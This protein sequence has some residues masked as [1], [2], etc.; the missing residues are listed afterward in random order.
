MASLDDD[1][2]IVVVLHYWA[3]LTLEGVADRVGWPIGTVKSRSHRALTTMRGR[4]DVQRSR[5]TVDDRRRRHPPARRSWQRPAAGGAHGPARLPRRAWVSGGPRP[6]GADAVLCCLSLSSRSPRSFSASSPWWRIVPKA[7]A[8]TRTR[9]LDNIDLGG[10]YLTRPRVRQGRASPRPTEWLDDETAAV[11]DPGDAGGSSRRLF[12]PRHD[13]LPVDRK[14]AAD[15]RRMRDGRHS[16]R[17]RDSGDHR[18]D[19]PV[20]VGPGNLRSIDD[21]R[22]SGRI[23]AAR[24]HPVGLGH[25]VP[26]GG[27]Y[28]LVLNSPKK[29]E[30]AANSPSCRGHLTAST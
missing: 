1:H 22:L 13:D 2:R 27:L 17:D 14:P 6:I 7:F 21:R 5:R 18:G 25:R 3:D 23:Q 8:D 20:P 16:T 28:E 29:D 19:P 26:H 30:M 4:M 12:H 9:G 11:S 10:A 24:R 15:T